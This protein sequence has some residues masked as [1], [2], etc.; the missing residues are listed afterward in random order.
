VA[1]CRL[2]RAQGKE[3]LRV[4]RNP[5]ARECIEGNRAAKHVNEIV[6]EQLALER[7]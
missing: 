6:D 5:E 2:S 7:K 1:A 4:A 3:S